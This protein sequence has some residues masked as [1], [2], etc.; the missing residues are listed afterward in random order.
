[1]ENAYYYQICVDLFWC[2]TKCCSISD[3]GYE[4]LQ[5]L[6]NFSWIRFKCGCPNFTNSSL[7]ATKSLDL[8]NPFSILDSECSDAENISNHHDQPLTSTPTDP[9]KSRA[10]FPTPQNRRHGLK[11]MVINC[12]GLKSIAKRSALRATVEHHKPDIIMGCES[13]ISNSIPT[14]SIFP[15]NY[16]IYRNDRNVNGVFIA[17]KESLISVDLSKIP[18]GGIPST[19]VGLSP[20]PPCFIRFI[21]TL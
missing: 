18:W 2:H 12:N 15:S 11:A 19:P 21:I 13:K 20:S 14:G 6:S 10:R 3:H 1:M 8:S 9:T 17:T 16:T 4:H 5:H 7:F